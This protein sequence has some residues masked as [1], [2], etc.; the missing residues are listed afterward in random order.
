MSVG[1]RQEEAS[2][3][4]HPRHFL[5]SLTRTVN[6]ATKMCQMNDRPHCV[7]DTEDEEVG[8]FARIF[9]KVDELCCLSYSTNQILDELNDACCSAGGAAVFCTPPVPDDGIAGA[10]SRP[11]HVVDDP[12]RYSDSYRRIVSGPAD[13]A[14]DKIPTHDDLD[15]EDLEEIEMQSEVERHEGISSWLMPNTGSDACSP[16]DSHSPSME[17]FTHPL[18][19]WDV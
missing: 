8:W 12:V 5:A 3:R 7:D 4:G 18:K 13:V 15:H 6:L 16:Y 19:V 14:Y 2:V 9:L 11:V 1:V 10:V 17:G